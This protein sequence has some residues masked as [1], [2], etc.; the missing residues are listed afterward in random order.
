MQLGPLKGTAH[1]LGHLVL[2]VSMQTRTELFTPTIS[3]HLQLGPLDGSTHPQSRTP[4]TEATA[5]SLIGR[6][7]EAVGRCRLM[8]APARLPAAVRLLYVGEAPYDGTMPGSLMEH[9]PRCGSVVHS[10]W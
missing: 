8:V 5:A 1:T 4:L 10:L 2:T 3:S 6:N 9:L 7:G